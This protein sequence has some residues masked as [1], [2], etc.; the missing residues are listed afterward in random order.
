MKLDW[1]AKHGPVTG[2]INTGLA[3]LAVGYAG[4]TVGM[5][6]QWAALTAGAGAVGTH[7]AG[8]RRKVT[9][10]TLALRAAGW[11]GAGGWCSWAIANSPWTQ[12]G[13]GS[14]VVGALGLGAAMAGAHRVEEKAEEQRIEAEAAARRATLDGK[15][16]KIADEWEDRIVRVCG[17]A[18]VQIVGVE[19]WESGGGFSLDG[20]CGQ[21]G[22]RWKDIATWKDQLASDARLPEGC[23]VEV[24]PGA[25]RGAVL[26]EVSTVNRLVDD[27][28]YPDDYSP[29]TVNQPAAI[30]V[31]RD[32]RA[33]GPVNR[34]TSMLLVGQRESGKTNLMNV[35]VGNNCRMTDSLSWVIDLNGGGLALKWMRAWAAA[36]KPGRPPIDWV[37]D[38]PHKA[39][40]MAA[41]MVRIAKA[42]KVGYQDREIAANDDKLPVDHEVPE[43]RVFCDEGAEIFSTRSRRDET[44][45]GIADD[46]IQ[47]LEIARAAAV[48]ETT[49]GL[50]ATQ[51][52]L[53]DPQILKQSTFKAGLRVSDDAE[54]NYFFGYN[55][56]ASAEDAPYPGCALVRSGT[57]QVHPLK[58]YRLKPNQIL[59]I[60]QATA[61]R[62]PELDALS[63]QAAGKAYEQRWMDTDH[64][65]GGPVPA[66][67]AVEETPPPATAPRPRGVTADW[68]SAPAGGEA[69]ATIDKAEE[70]R[71]KLR[72]AM[73][74]AGSRDG[75]LDAKFMDIIAGGGVTWQ[76]PT[77]QPSPV[78]APTEDG[79][80][81]KE[82]VFGIV[83]KA[84]AD[85]IGP[86]A[87]REIFDRFFRPHGYETPHAATIGR[88]LGADPRV[89]KP[90]YGR[91]AVRPDQS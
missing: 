67:V 65:F 43:I 44:L 32:G 49:S 15:R 54:L 17:G 2:P 79:D 21:G 46:L 91:Y 4:H 56:N 71:R 72:E 11:L 23:G 74:D 77:E 20:E 26:I 73:N 50:R 24:G 89:H 29:L 19:V 64:L 84:G 86:E 52:V 16:Q 33:E 39:R 35:M 55:H 12:W 58:I 10:A 28:Y 27:V 80:P 36:G 62:R 78:A 90:G 85:G 88:W 38:T 69:Q 42:R 82:M 34:Q 48:N 81:R 70:A 31:L 22:T 45:R 66:P 68:G 25:H 47:T 53:A 40:E 41:A 57:G 76:P 3:T 83:E 63:R 7:V 75:D 51:D 60:V 59:D 87:I 13:I 14:L 18:V 30:G 61:S 37:A 6:W 9:T 8:R 1:D 5:P